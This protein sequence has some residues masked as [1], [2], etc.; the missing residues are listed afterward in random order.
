[1]PIA[2]PILVLQPTFTV[3]NSVQPGGIHPT[4]NQTTGGNG[5][6]T[7]QE[8][9]IAVSFT[10]PFDLAADHYFFVPQVQLS[11]G[12]FFWLSAP[13]PIVPPGR[14]SPPVSPIFRAGHEINSWS[15]TGCGSAPTSVGQGA[16]NAAF[17][18]NGVT[19]PGPIAGAGLPGLMGA[20]GALLMRARRRRKATT[21]T[22]TPI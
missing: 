10:T 7:G 4:P 18:L 6:V 5:P 22:P 3:D 13:R 11:S 15:P 19:V 21:A 20:C 16:F 2:Q 17:V 9:Q 12:D 8:T 14:P 1:M